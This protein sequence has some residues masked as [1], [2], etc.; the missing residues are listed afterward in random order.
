MAVSYKTYKL[1]ITCLLIAGYGQIIAADD[2]PFIDDKSDT[3]IYPNYTYE[4]IPDYNYSEIER[5][6]LQIESE[7]PLSFNTR[8]KA[9]IDYFTIKD[10]AY[11]KNV[12]GKLD[13]YFPLF[14]KYFREYNIPEEIK[15]LAI[16]ESGLNPKA[17][18]PVGAVGLW[19]FMPYTARMY[20]LKIDWYI[21]ERMDPEKSTIAACKYLQLL[22]DSFDDWE[23][24][25]AA[26]NCGPGNVRRA[27]RRSGYKKKFWEIYR[28][29]PRE[30]RSY[31]PQFMA[32]MYV[33][34][35]AEEHNFYIEDYKEYF[36]ETDTLIV[37]EFLYLKTFADLTNTCAEDLE[38]MN[39]MVRRRAFPETGNKY[40]FNIPADIKD[41]VQENRDY[42]LDSARNTGKEE[43]EYLARNS[44][45][46][47]WGRDKIVHRV[48][49]GEV[50]GSIAANYKVRV[51]D[52]R[53][54]NNIQGSLIR[55]NQKLDIYVNERYY[56][57]VNN[58]KPVVSKPVSIPQPSASD[59]VHLVQPGDSLWK[60]S[61]QYEGLTIEKIKKLNNLKSNRIKPG[62]KLIIG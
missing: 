19:Q 55:V 49:S 25:M 32:F 60:I 31:V 35:Y 13:L 3:L 16:V 41:Y 6:F 53:S 51:A 62:Q 28:Y 34:N 29:L 52:I 8:I 40:V 4:H 54:W 9:F 50:L 12:L 42:I 21:D 1:L 22:Y 23:L 48:R 39:P 27:I 59:K 58:T 14:E 2:T 43:L 37:D 47:T 38:K 46:S 57:S 26:Y 36:P 61:R 17:R 15:Y 5:Q 45:G 56:N 33:I 20:G 24:A 7:I 11:T 44:V 10:R 18:S 30:T